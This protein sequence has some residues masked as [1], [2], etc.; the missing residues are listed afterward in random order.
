MAL[1]GITTKKAPEGPLAKFARKLKLIPKVIEP[2]PNR[3]DRLYGKG[4]QS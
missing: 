4:K 1:F 2:N 3:A